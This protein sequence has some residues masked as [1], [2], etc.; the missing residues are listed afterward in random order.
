VVDLIG[1]VLRLLLRLVRRVIGIGILLVL[2]QYSTYPIGLTWNAVSILTSEYQFDYVKWE[3]DALAVKVNET[4][5]GLHPFMSETNRVQYVRRYM[6]KLREAQNLEAQISV[7]FSDPNITDAQVASAS[8]RMQRD[9]LRAELQ[10]QQP[11][12]EGILEGQVATVLIEQGFGSG[13][14]LLP[15]ISAHFTQVPNLLVVSPRDKISFDVSIN[16]NPMTVDAIDGLE[17][18]VDGLENLSALVVPLGGIALYPSM[19]L[20]TSSIPY[21][22]DTISHEWLHHYLF[23]FPLGLQYFNA[24]SFVGETRIINET[25]ASLFGH[26]MS[27]LMLAKYYPDL[28]PPPPKP[29]SNNVAPPPSPATPKFDFG[30]E[31]DKTRRQVDALLAE[32]KVVEAEAYM[33]MRRAEFVRNGYVIRKL[34]QAYFAFYGGYQSGAPGVGGADPIGPAIQALRDVSPSLQAWVIKMRGI[35]SR[36]QLLAE[37]DQLAR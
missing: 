20:E 25:T 37:R 15:P 24:D 14:Q 32:K 12:V 36:S 11:L 5:Y 4:L 17:N 35:T 13:G 22:L 1:R 16:L 33:N 28:L 23:F 18:R 7:I 10:R 27:R 21:A 34:N 8:L 3:L 30:T 2:L 9:Q 31:M 29:A 26:E 6:D 19:I